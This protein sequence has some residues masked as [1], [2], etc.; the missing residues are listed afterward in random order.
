[1]VKIVYAF[2]KEKH[3]FRHTCCYPVPQLE[4]EL[5]SRWPVTQLTLPCEL[6]G[7]LELSL[8]CHIGSGDKIPCDN[9]ELC[10]QASTNELHFF[11]HG[12]R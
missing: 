7:A 8:G 1:M 11:Y 3:F 4:L 6:A 12:L 5:N 9:I 10:S 2:G